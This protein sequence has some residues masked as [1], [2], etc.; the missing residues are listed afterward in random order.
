MVS[1]EHE[2]V[3]GTRGSGIVTSAAD[4]LGITADQMDGEAGWWTQAGRSDSPH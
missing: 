4:V 2:C 1:V 3:C